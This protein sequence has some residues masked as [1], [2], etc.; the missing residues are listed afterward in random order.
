MLLDV[1]ASVFDLQDFGVTGLSVHLQ[2]QQNDE[3]RAWM[4]L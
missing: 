3:E 1:L 4:C 2:L